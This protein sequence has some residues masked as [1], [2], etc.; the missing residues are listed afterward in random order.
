VQSKKK[1]LS[2]AQTPSLRE[3]RQLALEK[4]GYDVFSPGDLNEIEKLCKTSSFDVAVIGHRFDPTTKRTIAETIRKYCPAIKIVELT[5]SYADIPGSI[6][7]KPDTDELVANVQAMVK[8][9]KHT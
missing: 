2:V 6:T 3:E 8:G 1:I 4:V 5:E 7:S 9:A